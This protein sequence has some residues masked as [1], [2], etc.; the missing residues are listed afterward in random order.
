VGFVACA[1][2]IA[3]ELADIKIVTGLTTSQFTERLIYS[4]LVEGRYRKYLSRLRERVGEARLNV[5]R[6]FEH[7]GLELFAEP[8][9]G[10]LIW[11]RF[12]HIADSLPLAEISPRDGI[13][14]AP[15]VAFRPNL[16]ASPWLRFNVAFCDDGRLNDWLQRQVAGKAD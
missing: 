4:T 9:D 12:P 8:T 16:E 14:L 6:A 10:V 11:A 1:Q 3:S 7:I 2:H 5:V 15:G 13:L